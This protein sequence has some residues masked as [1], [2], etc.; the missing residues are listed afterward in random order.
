MSALSI[1]GSVNAA[2]IKAEYDSSTSSLSI[3][4]AYNEDLI[5]KIIDYNFNP[6]LLG[7]FFTSMT[8]F[9]LSSFS[10][11]DNNLSLQFYSNE[12]YVFT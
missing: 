8:A 6:V 1:S 5:G 4:T 7:S 9:P 10:T 3:T 12:V 2:I 11:V